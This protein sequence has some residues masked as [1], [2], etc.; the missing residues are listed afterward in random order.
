[1][2]LPLKK[3]EQMTQ[4]VSMFFLDS[5]HTRYKPVLVQK[6]DEDLLEEGQELFKPQETRECSF[7][8]RLLK[9]FQRV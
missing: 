2:N 8:K 4:A 1:V 7:F 9:C 6:R 5:R 3:K